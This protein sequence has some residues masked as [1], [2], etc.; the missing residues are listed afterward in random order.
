M[1]RIALH[2]S[3]WLAAPCW[4]TPGATAGP[5]I[6]SKPVTETFTNGNG[7]AMTSLAPTASASASASTSGSAEAILKYFFAVDGPEGTTAH[8]TASKTLSFN[9]AGVGPPEGPDQGFYT[10]F[11]ACS[12]GPNNF[13]EIGGESGQP[14]TSPLSEL[15]GKTIVVD[16]FS[17]P[18]LT[19][20]EIDLTAAGLSFVSLGHPEVVVQAF[21]DPIIAFDPAF[22]HSG[23]SLVFSPGIGNGSPTAVPE[24]S[25]LMLCAL[26]GAVGLVG[27]ARRRSKHAE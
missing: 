2:F 9:V 3:V 23:L 26:A 17:T 5:V 11:A 24:P 27:Y 13:D 8:V 20:I 18:T 14:P 12:F 15:S 10:V 16:K 6:L 4:A 7:S 1:R 22:D 25:S 21:A 19:P